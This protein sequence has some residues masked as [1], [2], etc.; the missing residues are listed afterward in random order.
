MVLCCKSS[1]CLMLYNVPGRYDNGDW[2]LTFI[3][4]AL[5]DVIGLWA[6]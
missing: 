1:I 2:P 5:R 4:N 6:T 3:Y